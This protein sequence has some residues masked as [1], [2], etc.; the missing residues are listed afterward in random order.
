MSAKLLKK[1]S[2]ADLEAELARRKK[3]K[4]AGDRPKPLPNPDFSRVV[5][6]FEQ[7]LDQL[8][9]EGYWDDDANHYIYEET[10]K[11]I[12]GPDFFKWKNKKV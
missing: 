1:V 10:A 8:D 6:T 12:Y 9:A 5:E 2:D 11:A 3:D 7:F 4:E